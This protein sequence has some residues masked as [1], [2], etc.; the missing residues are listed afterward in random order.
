MRMKTDDCGMLRQKLVS[1]HIFFFFLRNNERTM[2]RNTAVSKT[3]STLHFALEAGSTA[4]LHNFL[5]GLFAP[6]PVNKCKSWI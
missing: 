4:I 3:F 2:A 5:I 1:K 6:S